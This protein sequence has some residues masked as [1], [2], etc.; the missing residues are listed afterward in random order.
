MEYV[1]LNALLLIANILTVN[2]SF[3]CYTEYM[4]DKSMDKRTKDNKGE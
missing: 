3:K 1:I 2:I 4:K